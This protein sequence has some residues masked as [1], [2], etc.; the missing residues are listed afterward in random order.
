MS[1]HQP[2]HNTTDT[3]PGSV[4]LAPDCHKSDT[5]SRQDEREGQAEKSKNNRRPALMRQ[6]GETNSNLWTDEA[7]VMS[8][9][10]LRQLKTLK[11]DIKPIIHYSLNCLYLVCISYA[12]QTSSKSEGGVYFSMFTYVCVD[13]THT[14]LNVYHL[15]LYT[16]STSCLFFFSCNLCCAVA[17]FSQQRHLVFNRVPTDC[18]IY[19]N[20]VMLQFSCF[21]SLICLFL[22]S[23]GLGY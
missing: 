9:C 7:L 11:L 4:P 15:F 5:A 1:R 16:K 22:N 23:Q 2:S 6:G 8:I 20:I 18:V 12:N 3:N 13:H 17:S 10:K 21:N 19:S 14:S